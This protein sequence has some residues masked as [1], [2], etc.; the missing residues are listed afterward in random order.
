MT[1][2][3]S[4]FMS[5]DEP[6]IRVKG[7]STIIELL[8]DHASWKEEAGSNKM[9]WFLSR[10]TRVR[11]EYDVFVLVRK[12]TGQLRSVRLVGKKIQIHRDPQSWVEIQ[13]TGNKTK[14]TSHRERLTLGGFDQVLS[15]VHHIA[16]IKVDSKVP[17]LPGDGE[18]IEVLI[19]DTAK[20]R[21]S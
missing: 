16:E 14:V 5:G 9:K 21:R 20:I 12:P 19:L 11:N 7:G 15:H 17:F 18:L 4:E 1:E 2:E 10:G 13:A 8:D 6:P 3:L